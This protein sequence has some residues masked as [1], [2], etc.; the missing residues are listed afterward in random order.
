[1]KLYLKIKSFNAGDKQVKKFPTW[2]TWFWQKYFPY[3]PYK[4]IEFGQHTLRDFEVPVN[5]RL[6][7]PKSRTNIEF[8]YLLYKNVRVWM[9]KHDKSSTLL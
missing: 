9:I 2:K 5:N 8:H 7:Q 6:I 4:Y 1:M 3:K